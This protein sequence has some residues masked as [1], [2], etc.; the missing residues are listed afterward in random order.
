[1]SLVFGMR[2]RYRLVAIASVRSCPIMIFHL[3]TVSVRMTIRHVITVQRRTLG[4]S[5]ARDSQPSP[6]TYLLSPRSH[7]SST[8]FILPA[9]PHVIDHVKSWLACQALRCL[10]FQLPAPPK[11]HYRRVSYGCTLYPPRYCQPDSAPHVHLEH[12]CNVPRGAS[13]TPDNGT[14]GEVMIHLCWQIPRQI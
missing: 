13:A 1:M 8:T 4:L 11:P 12:T 5:L 7:P 9:K 6:S 14:S 2:L 3:I 10:S